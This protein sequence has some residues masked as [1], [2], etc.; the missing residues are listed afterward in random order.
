VRDSVLL[1]YY[2]NPQGGGWNLRF[3]SVPLKRFTER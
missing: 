1:T 3:R 2:D